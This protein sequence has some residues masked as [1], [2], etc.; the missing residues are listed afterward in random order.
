ML[1]E[2]CE[3]IT[4]I[5][6]RNSKRVDT[7]SLHLIRLLVLPSAE[8][9]MAAPMGSISPVFEWKFSIKI[10]DAIPRHSRRQAIAHG[11]IEHARRSAKRA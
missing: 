5:K 10:D 3:Q 8:H 11:Q 4:I 9:E 1:S 2:F 7:Q 6:Q